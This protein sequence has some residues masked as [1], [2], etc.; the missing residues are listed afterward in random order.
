MI[1]WLA[2]I[3]PALAAPILRALGYVAAYLAGRRARHQEQELAN[4][5]GQ[6]ARAQAEAEAAR[7]GR[8]ANLA[9]MRANRPKHVQPISLDRDPRGG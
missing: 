2:G 5:K 8:A 7:A 9:W 1:T 3:L 4:A 6:I